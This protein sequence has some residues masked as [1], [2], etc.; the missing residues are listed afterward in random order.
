MTLVLSISA[1]QEPADC[2]RLRPY[3]IAQTNITRNRQRPL[4]DDIADLGIECGDPGGGNR[5]DYHTLVRSMIRADQCAPKRIDVAR[6]ALIGLANHGDAIFDG[7][8]RGH[9]GM[10]FADL[11]PEISWRKQNVHT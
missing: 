6:H 9:I 4:A 10:K 3:R 5:G 7:A 11:R 2:P 8:E 1:G